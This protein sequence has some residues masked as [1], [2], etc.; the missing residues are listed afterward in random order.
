[1]KDSTK[2]HGGSKAGSREKGRAGGSEGNQGM[3]GLQRDAGEIKRDQG[4][5]SLEREAG[6]FKD[7]RPLGGRQGPKFGKELPK[8]GCLPKLFM[9]S[10]PLII[11]AAYWSLSF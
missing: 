10:L 4:V 11:V 2:G 1:M 5:G 7:S 3:G 9:L 6:D 8:K